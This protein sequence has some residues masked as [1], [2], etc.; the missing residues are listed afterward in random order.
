MSLHCSAT[1]RIR[2]LVR[3]AAVAATRPALSVLLLSLAAFAQ[4]TAQNA[5]ALGRAKLAEMIAFVRLASEACP[6]AVPIVWTLEALGL[7]MIAKPPVQEEEIVAKKPSRPR[8]LVR[9]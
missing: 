4:S 2:I 9:E 5:D 3:S 7:L 6:N 1:A 8:H